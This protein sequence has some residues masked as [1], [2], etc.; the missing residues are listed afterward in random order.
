GGGARAGG[1][2]ERRGEMRGD[3]HGVESYHAPGTRSADDGTK[4]HLVNLDLSFAHSPRLSSSPEPGW[5]G[6][7]AACGSAGVSVAV[8]EGGV[9]LC[10]PPEGAD[11]GIA[12]GA[13]SFAG[14]DERHARMSSSS[15]W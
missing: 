15:F 4:C 8:A 11:G 5:G 7:G 3:G 10:G 6:A 2:G 14:T 12:S 9:A 13:R 1:A